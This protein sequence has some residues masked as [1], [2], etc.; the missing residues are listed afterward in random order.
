V[1]AR[2]VGLTRSTIYSLAGIEGFAG[3]IVLFAADVQIATYCVIVNT[4]IRS[5]PDHIIGLRQSDPRRCENPVQLSCNGCCRALLGDSMMCEI[6]PE[7]DSRGHAWRIPTQVAITTKT[8]RITLM[9]A[10]MDT[11]VLTSHRNI[12]ATIRPTARGKTLCYNL[13][14]LDCIVRNPTARAM[15]R[16]WKRIVGTTKRSTDAVTARLQVMN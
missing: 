3:G 1:I 12:P 14:V 8:F 6:I 11:Y 2:I 13:P 7:S 15:V 4:E 5:L 9:L 10:A 16:D